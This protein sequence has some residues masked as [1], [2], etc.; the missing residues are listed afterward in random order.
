MRCREPILHRSSVQISITSFNGMRKSNRGHRADFL[1]T[2]PT[3]GKERL[4]HGHGE[5]NENDR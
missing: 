4:V 5:R 1:V 2:W 3:F